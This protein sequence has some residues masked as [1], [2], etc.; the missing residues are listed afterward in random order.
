[1]TRQTWEEERDARRIES[2]ERLLE[3]ILFTEERLLVLMAEVLRRLP[4][5]PTFRPTKAIVVIV[6][7]VQP[8]K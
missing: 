4:P 5:P 8:K 3:R 2:T 1:M 6:D 7:P